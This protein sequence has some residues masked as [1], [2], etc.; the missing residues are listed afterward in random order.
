MQARASSCRIV[1]DSASLQIP[2]VLIPLKSWKEPQAPANSL[3]HCRVGF[4]VG[5]LEYFEQLTSFSL[6]ALL[7]PTRINN[8]TT[9]T[10]HVFSSFRAGCKERRA[11][12]AHWRLLLHTALCCALLHK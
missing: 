5:S 10:T 1:C 11:A 3:P 4:P 9:G 7:D 12:G 8:F 6:R 2:E